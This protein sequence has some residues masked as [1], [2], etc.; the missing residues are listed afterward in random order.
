MAQK[1]LT[2]RSNPDPLETEWIFKGMKLPRP[3]TKPNGD[4]RGLHITF[5]PEEITLGLETFPSNRVLQTDNQDLF[6]LASF[7]ALRFKDVSPS[8]NI[9]YIKRFLKSGLNLNG[10]QYWFYGHSN[11]QLRSRSCFLRKGQNE[12]ELHKRILDLGEFGSIKSAAKCK[13]TRPRGSVLIYWPDQ[14]PSALDSFSPVQLWTGLL[15]RSMS[16]STHILPWYKE[17]IQ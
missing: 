8:V 6:V 16:K 3:I 2:L 10:Q 13:H 17:A 11:S 9:D 1:P 14:Y 15:N 5:T 12:A 4:Y 7:S